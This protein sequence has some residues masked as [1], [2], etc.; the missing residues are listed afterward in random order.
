MKLVVFSHKAIWVKKDSPSG[1]ATDGGFAFHMK[2]ISEIFEETQLVLPLNTQRQHKGEVNIEGKN[3]QVFP[4][5]KIKGSG[6][7]RKVRYLPWFLKNI[8]VFNRLINSADAVHVPI[9]SDIGTLG[10]V[11]AKVKSKPLFVRYC[12]NWLVRQTLAERFWV[13]FMEKYAGGKNV[14]LATG[15]QPSPPSVKNS[16]IHWIF[17]SS[18]TQEEI[19]R[20]SGKLPDLDINNPRLAIVGRMSEAKGHRRVIKAVDILKDEYPGMH[21]D[22]VGDGP[23]LDDFKAFTQS[24]G[25]NNMVTFHG[26]L[27]HEDV[28]SVLSGA[29]IFC[30]PTTSS[31]GFPKVV[32]EAMACGLPVLATPVSAIRQL[33]MFGGG[34]TLENAT[35]EVLAVALKTVLCDVVKY[36]H[37]Q[38]KAIETA[39]EF[40]LEKW[41]DTI[42]KHLEKAWQK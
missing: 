6:L 11:L 14:M 15:F 22:V 28:I 42:N 32:I 29:Q 3:I 20:L 1:F 33:L 31:E 36:K 7:G 12:G 5:K 37:M 34:V 40:S 30:F 41:R 24:L 8:F 16:N 10:M 25:I 17:S 38:K 4:V 21:L 39:R 9:P 27:N 23:A 18:L 35:P 13:W 19:N 26:K 2:A